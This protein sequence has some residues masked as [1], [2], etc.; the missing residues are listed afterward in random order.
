MTFD[1]KWLLLG[2]ASLVLACSP[3][4]GT[5]S[6]NSTAAVA[7]PAAE[8]SETVAPE[9]MTPAAPASA[10]KVALSGSADA[11]AIAQTKT[12]AAGE[13]MAKVQ[14]TSAQSFGL[15]VDGQRAAS[16][17]TGEASLSNGTPGCFAAIVQDGKASLVPT[18]GQGEY[19]AESCDKPTAV[20]ILS[21][22][23]DVVRIGAVFGAFSP[24]ATVSEPIVLNWSRSTGAFSIDAA[25]SSKASQAGA[26]TI[27][28]MRSAVQ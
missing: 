11:E 18:I 16:I 1:P 24:N 22:S 26:Q 2:A 27:A 19:E 14:I 13:Q 7:T 6:G 9:P 5:A 12:A 17:V 15:S 10:G 23:G 8:P 25:G 4:A 28:A 20:G 3:E 21:S